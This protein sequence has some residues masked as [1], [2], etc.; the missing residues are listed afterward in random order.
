METIVE[1]PEFQRR[2]ASLISEHEKQGIINYLAAHP[3]TGILM[4]GTGGIRKFRWT[5]GNKGKS[6]GVRVI[7]YYHN[8]TMPLFLLSLFGKSEKTNLTKSER[9]ELAKFTEHLVKNYGA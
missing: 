7:Y 2:A 4:Q 3:Q 6:G 5:S 9:N 1:L 8:E